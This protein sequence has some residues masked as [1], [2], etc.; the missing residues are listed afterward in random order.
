MTSPS[1]YALLPSSWWVMN[2]VARL[3]RRVLYTEGHP[4]RGGLCM[5]GG[6]HGA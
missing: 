2:L 6:H 5:H 4:T 3:E 1:R